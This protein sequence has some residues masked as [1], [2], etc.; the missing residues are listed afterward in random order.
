MSVCPEPPRILSQGQHGCYWSIPGVL[1][2]HRNKRGLIKLQ[3][4]IPLRSDDS[5]CYETLVVLYNFQTKSR[6]DS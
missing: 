3:K 6:A 5:A 4:E 1:M 2:N